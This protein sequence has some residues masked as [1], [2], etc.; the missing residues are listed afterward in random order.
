M[1]VQTEVF[2][3]KIDIVDYQDD[4]IISECMET[5]QEVTCTQPLS[6][7]FA[8]DKVSLINLAR[9]K[10]G[11][12]S[13]DWGTGTMKHRM[14]Y[15]GGRN[16]EA[17]AKAVLGQMKN[18]IVFDATAGLG[19][20][21][22]ICAYL[23]GDVHL[24][25]RHPCVRILLKDGIRRA[26][27]NDVIAELV[28]NNIHLEEAHTIFEYQGDVLPDTIYMDPMYPER[29]KSSNVKKEMDTFHYLVGEDL[30]V[31]ELWDK[32]MH[33]S[34]KR[35]VMKNPKWAPIQNSKRLSGSVV[36][37]NHRFDI[38]VPFEK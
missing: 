27:Q 9:Q 11:G 24:F 19:R 21:A 38:F 18:P 12:I 33:L 35:V 28:H 25:E 7:V 37:K 34:H 36:T 15:G 5:C 32:A 14:N 16:S 29:V 10:Q 13:V 6:L 8:D 30:D 31:S 1:I 26:L 2:K 22:F 23:G 17:V 4:E 20:D 3:L